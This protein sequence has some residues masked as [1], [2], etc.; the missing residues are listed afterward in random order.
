MPVLCITTVTSGVPLEQVLAVSKAVAADGPPAGGISH[1]IVEE[2]GVIRSYDVFESEQAL[3]AFEQER[4]LPEIRKSM[5]ALGM[6][7]EPPRPE[8]QIL[9]CQEVMALNYRA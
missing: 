8:Q 9:E 3:R 2:D 1:V 4:L 7:G 6:E 5:A